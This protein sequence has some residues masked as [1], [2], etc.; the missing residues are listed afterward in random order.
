MARRYRFSLTDVLEAI[1]L[2]WLPIILDE[3]KFPQHVGPDAN[4]VQRAKS[5][6]DGLEAQDVGPVVEALEKLLVDEDQRRLQAEGKAN[7]LIGYTAITSGFVVGFAQFLFGTTV[8]A[9][10][11]RLTITFLYICITVAVLMTVILAMRAMRVTAFQ[12]P[13]VMEL[14]DVRDFNRE[15][16]FK[17]RAASLLDAYHYNQVTINKK[18]TYIRGAQDWFRNVVYLLVVLM[19]AMTT[20]LVANPYLVGQSQPTPL[21]VIITT[22]IPTASHGSTATARPI[23]TATATAAPA[24]TATVTPSTVPLPTQTITPAGTPTSVSPVIPSSAP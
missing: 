23:A 3:R 24:L 19:A 18:V 7:A 15:T 11:F 9:P 17:Q 12:Q 8:M 20:M 16:I 5:R 1:G 14:F 4:S 21:P 6:I 22:V 2:D 13:T 10:V